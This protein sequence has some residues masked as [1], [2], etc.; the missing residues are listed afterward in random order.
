MII[1]RIKLT[2]VIVYLCWCH[3]RHPVMF[4]VTLWF[5]VSQLWL[6]LEQGSYIHRQ[7]WNELRWQLY[8]SFYKQTFFKRHSSL[9]STFRMW[10]ANRRYHLQ[11][12][13]FEMFFFSFSVY[14]FLFNIKDNKMPFHFLVF[15]KQNKTKVP[16][17]THYLY[18]ISTPQ[19]PMLLK[20]LAS[21]SSNDSNKIITNNQRILNPFSNPI[22]PQTH[23]NHQSAFK[24]KCS[25][26]KPHIGI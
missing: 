19:P 15:K 7:Q 21:Y 3:Q 6:N 4:S 12:A 11:D 13:H 18:A 22:P 5:T 25:T 17:I 16:G 8:S 24:Q 26:T 10:S 23:K 14:L 1:Q 9:P 20:V 2:V